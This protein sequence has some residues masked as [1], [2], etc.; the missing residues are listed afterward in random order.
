VW[1]FNR[2]LSFKKTK[3]KEIYERLLDSTWY[4]VSCTTL[5][6]YEERRVG[7][8]RNKDLDIF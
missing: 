1:N 8:D 5:I 3:I 6:V 4:Q 7:Q 2:R